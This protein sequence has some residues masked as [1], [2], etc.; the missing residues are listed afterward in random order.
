MERSFRDN[1]GPRPDRGRPRADRAASV[2]RG[3]SGTDPSWPRRVGE[4]EPPD[5]SLTH[6]LFIAL[7][8]P[9]PAIEEIGSFINGMPTMAGTNVRWT[10][11]ENVHLTLLFLGD[12]ATERIPLIREQLNQA[13]ANSSPFTLR[14][15]ET[16]AFPSL[17]APRILWVGLQGEIHK[18]MQL[19]GR[20]EG[21]LRTI[22]FEP[23]RRPF[24]PHITV[25]RGVRDLEAQFAGDVGF[26]WRRSMLPKERA[27]VPINEIQ[28]IRSR[29]Q[30]G[31]TYYEKAFGVGLGR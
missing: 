26:S 6:R 25:G 7:A 18:L 11:R 2:Q 23:E 15:G 20:I 5:L 24:T 4:P 14:L 16:G 29:L 22:H 8:L 12:T 27:A 3:P 30:T 9:A 28:L 31:G 21:T 13:A 1:Q 19:Q 17:H 10:P